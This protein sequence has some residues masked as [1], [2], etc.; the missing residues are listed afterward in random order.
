[1]DVIVVFCE[2]LPVLGEHLNVAVTNPLIE[3]VNRLCLPLEGQCALANGSFSSSNF[4]E[5]S[6][7]DCLIGNYATYR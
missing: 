4:P 5:S 2:N 7:D 6:V 3:F 1:V